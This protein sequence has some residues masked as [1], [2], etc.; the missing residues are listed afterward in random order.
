MLLSLCHP[1]VKSQIY[2]LW[3]CAG[4]ISLRVINNDIRSLCLPEQ[5]SGR[6]N[7]LWKCPGGVSLRHKEC[8]P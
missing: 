3:K 1:A 7:V 2:I 4:G 5:R 8:Y 6:Y